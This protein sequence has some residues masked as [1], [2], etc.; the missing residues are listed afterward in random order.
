MQLET[1]QTREPL[2]VGIDDACHLTGLR[3]TKVLELAY[4][5]DI[6]SVKVGARRLF[7]VAGLREWVD[8]KMAETSGD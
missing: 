6:P 5:R 3:R 1:F 7:P 8:R 4:S 2:M